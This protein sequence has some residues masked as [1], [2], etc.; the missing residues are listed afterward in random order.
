MEEEEEMS[1]DHQQAD[2]VKEVRH[3]YGSGKM[4][5]EEG[6]SGNG[7]DLHVKEIH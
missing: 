6:S 2:A 5:G 3:S 1:D 7:R 4:E